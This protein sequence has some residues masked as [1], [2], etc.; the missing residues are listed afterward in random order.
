VLGCAASAVIAVLLT[1]S[2]A[3]TPAPSGRDDAAIA[4]TTDPG[5]ADGA[6]QAADSWIDQDDLRKALL[7]EVDGGV[8]DAATTI[9]TKKPPLDARIADRARDAAPRDAAVR[10]A[11]DDRPPVD[12]PSPVAL[13]PPEHTVA[14]VSEVHIRVEFQ[15][16]SIEPVD[17]SVAAQLDQAAQM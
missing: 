6:V 9:G 8:R 11:V 12:A 2:C 13:D 7:G 16:N 14:P 3:T 15:S 17:R 1:K 5:P 4:R 10:V